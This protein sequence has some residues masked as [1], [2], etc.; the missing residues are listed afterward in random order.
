MITITLDAH[1]GKDQLNLLALPP[2][3]RQRLVWRAAENLRTVAKNNVQKQQDWNGRAWAPRRR[4]RRKMLM[5]MRKLIVITEKPQQNMAKLRFEGG[6]YGVHPGIVAGAHQS[7]HTYKVNYV[8]RLKVKPQGAGKDM[9]ST[10]RQ[11]RKLRE[12]G[13]KRPGK[14]KGQYRSASIGWI[15]ENIN[16]AQAGLLIKK[17]KGDP[18]KENW[19]VTL[20]ARPFL[21]ANARQ[22]QQ[23]FARALQSIDYGWDVNKQDLKRK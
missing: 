15:T 18:R 11:A 3:K 9:T 23:A 5:G 6:A 12:L 2:K 4:G 1:R 8:K 22:R 21:G 20:P 10:R 13:F 7:G 16:Y 17:L 14:R 19:D